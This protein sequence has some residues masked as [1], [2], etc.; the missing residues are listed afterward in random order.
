MKYQG[1][2]KDTEGRIKRLLISQNTND[3]REGFELLDHEYRVRMFGTLRVWSDRHHM[4]LCADDL[5]DAW[6]ETVVAL[7][8]IVVGGKFKPQKNLWSLLRK[9]AQCRVHDLIRSRYRSKRMR[10][11]LAQ[12]F[13][14][15]QGEGREGNDA[16]FSEEENVQNK[17]VQIVRSVLQEMK[18]RP[19]YQILIRTELEL[20]C[21]WPT[22]DD[23]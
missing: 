16:P 11:M 3:H 7:A 13:R 23:S 1:P 2:D 22:A 20:Y 12:I 4:R 17:K 5:R 15:G 6:Q 10:D 19:K 18:R 21:A 9:I 8:R 14:Q